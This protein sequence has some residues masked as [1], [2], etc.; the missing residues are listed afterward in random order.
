MPVYNH[1]C[2]EAGNSG[3]GLCVMQHLWTGG[4]DSPATL[5]TQYRVRYYIDGEACARHLHRT[6][7]LCA[8]AAASEGP[9]L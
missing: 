6:P 5:Y 2:P 9:R 1:T 4:S 8:S 3:A 7:V